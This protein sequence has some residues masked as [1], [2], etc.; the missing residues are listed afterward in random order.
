MRYQRYKKLGTEQLN[1]ATKRDLNNTRE[2][3]INVNTASGAIIT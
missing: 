1:I 2:T 3:I